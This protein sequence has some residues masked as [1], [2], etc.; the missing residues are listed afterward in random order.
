[1]S[2]V[3]YSVSQRKRNPYRGSGLLASAGQRCARVAVAVA[4][5]WVLTA[6]GMGWL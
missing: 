5:L 1:M 6:W 3:P 4:A 2:S